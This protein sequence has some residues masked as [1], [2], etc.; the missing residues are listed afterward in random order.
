MTKTN[1]HIVKINETK[2]N[3]KVNTQPASKIN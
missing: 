2:S 3:K 1:L